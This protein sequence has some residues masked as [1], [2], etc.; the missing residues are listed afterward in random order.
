MKVEVKLLARVQ[1]YLDAQFTRFTG[2]LLPCYECTL[3]P[4]KLC[5]AIHIYCF[6]I[7]SYVAMDKYDRYEDAN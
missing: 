4:K 3:G 7:V 1:S 2:N 5:N 6:W